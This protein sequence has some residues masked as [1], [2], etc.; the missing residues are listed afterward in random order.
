[1]EAF[2]DSDISVEE[3]IKIRSK[4]EQRLENLYFKDRLFFGFNNGGIV[5]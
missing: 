1:M 5:I 2:K 4:I 3:I